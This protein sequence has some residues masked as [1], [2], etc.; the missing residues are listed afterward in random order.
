MD[1]PRDLLLTLSTEMAA[2]TPKS[3]AGNVGELS[4]RYRGLQPVGA[5]QFVGSAEDATAY[6]AYRMPATFAATHAALAALRAGVPALRP[7]SLLDVGAGPGTAAWAAAQIWPGLDRATMLERD[8]KMIALGERLAAR[9]GA[10]AIR[11][12]T[13]RRV[14]IVGGAWELDAADLVVAGYLL[15]ELP[16]AQSEAFVA[17]LWSQSAGAVVIVEP[18]TPRGFATVRRARA[19]LIAAGATI[20]APC[21]HD[22]ECPMPATDWCHFAQRVARTPL[23]RAV[24]VGTLSYEDEKFAYVAATRLSLASRL[25]RVIRHPQIRKGL[26]MFQLCGPSGLE[27]RTISRRDGMLYRQARDVE[28]G[29]TLALGSDEERRRY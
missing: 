9:A 27:R 10:R 13:W 12:A 20:A 22:G 18:G 21:P 19:L 4:A 28:W 6:V 7:A 5:G 25:P 2:T 23:Q 16:P 15:G 14:D 17:R 11:E 3:L 26:V 8:Q 29:S 24:K 1:L